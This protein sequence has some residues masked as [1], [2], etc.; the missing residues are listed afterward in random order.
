MNQFP[1]TM[2]CQECCYPRE[3]RFHRDLSAPR[4]QSRIFGKA[5][6]ALWIKTTLQLP[7]LR[8]A[9]GQ[10]SPCCKRSERQLRPV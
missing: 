9:D 6:R 8:I 1:A 5:V 3:R 2:T 10:V 4:H 7:L